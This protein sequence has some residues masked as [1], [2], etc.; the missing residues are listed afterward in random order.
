MRCLCSGHLPGRVSRDPGSPEATCEPESVLQ[1]ASDPAVTPVLE[2]A[3][4]ATTTPIVHGEA[5]CPDLD[6]E[7]VDEETVVVLPSACGIRNEGGV[8]SPP[9]VAPT[10]RRFALPPLVFNRSCPPAA[11]GPRENPARPRMLGEFLAAAKSCS[12]ALLQTPAV[13]RRLF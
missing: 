1:G 13:R 3:L 8:T 12:D 4:V 7:Q 5:A 9:V 11:P 6:E 10:M 2:L